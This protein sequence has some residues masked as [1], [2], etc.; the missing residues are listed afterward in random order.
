[1]FQD[2]RATKGQQHF[3]LFGAIDLFCNTTY[4]KVKC[5]IPKVIFTHLPSL[6]NEV[7]V[8]EGH[9][10]QLRLSREESDQRRGE[11]LQQGAVVV[12]VFGQHLHELH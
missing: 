5:A 10:L 3:L 11:L 9:I 4:N 6:Y 8:S 2:L 12:Q 7:D 1:M